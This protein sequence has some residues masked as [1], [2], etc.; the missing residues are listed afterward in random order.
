M[1]KKTVGNFFTR[2]Y[3]PKDPRHG[4]FRCTPH[5]TKDG[6]LRDS[7]NCGCGAPAY[8][9]NYYR[10][11]DDKVTFEV[12]LLQGSGPIPLIIHEDEKE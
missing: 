12:R 6:S 5:M 4:D 9:V 3:C 10:D 11:D 2:L 7:T 1:S 8:A